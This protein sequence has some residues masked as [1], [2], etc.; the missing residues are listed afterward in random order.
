MPAGQRAQPRFGAVADHQRLV[1]GHQAGDI[2]FVGLELVVGFFQRGL[3][4][5][6]ILQFDHGQ[7]D[8]VGEEHDIR[9][10]VGAR[11]GGGIDVGDRELVH[12][13]PIVVG[14]VI[15]IEQP[16]LVV[17][18]LPLCRGIRHRRHR[19]AAVCTAW[20]LW[21]RLVDWRRC[22]LRRASSMTAVGPTAGCGC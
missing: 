6:R 7:G 16:D 13:Q 2:G 4:V 17:F 14:P 5:G 8:A 21:A 11:V 22:S 20:L 12:G 15:E 3:L 19:S 10:A 1:V 18:D 9:A